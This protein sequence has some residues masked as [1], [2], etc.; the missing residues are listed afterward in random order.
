[1][2]KQEGTQIILTK[3][4]FPLLYN[5]MPIIHA[6]SRQRYIYCASSIFTICRRE[7]VFSKLI[8]QFGR[9]R[10]FASGI[11]HLGIK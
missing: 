5:H 10:E 8:V 4:L 3:I 6:V 1:M 2:K 9:E 7:I 11:A